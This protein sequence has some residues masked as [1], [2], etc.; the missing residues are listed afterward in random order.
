MGWEDRPYYRDRS[1]S[2]GNI[3][4]SLLTGS[5][6]L[7]TAFG[8]RVRAHASL[9]IL[10]VMVTLF[11]S[12]KGF[13]AIQVR[14]TSMGMLFLIILLHEFGHC[15]AAR[16]VG[17][18]ANEILLWPLGGL[19]LASPPHR[20]W[21]TFVTVAGGPLVNVAICVVAGVVVWAVG[22]G[23][24]SFNPFYIFAPERTG[25][26]LY[27]GHHVAYEVAIYSCWVFRLS[28]W[29]FLFNMIPMFPLDGGQM[30]QSILWPIIGYF[31][32]MHFAC[33]TGM[34]GAVAL[35]IFGLYHQFNTLLVCT[36]IIGF[37][38]CRSRLG[39]LKEM[40]AEEYALENEGIDYSASLRPDVPV[41][42]RR[43]AN[44]WAIRRLR[45]QAQ[46]EAAEQQLIDTILAKVSA[47]GMHSLTW[48]ERRALK[49]ATERQRRRELEPS[50]KNR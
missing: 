42:K 28:Y 11:D 14:A 9:I 12:T 44:R 27:T 46:R 23:V 30:L 7:F 37:L 15:F 26:L 13:D 6:P 40:G 10:I 38:Y 16:S 18:D 5:V 48:S 19:A 4:W 50:H 49:R 3:F 20:P 35:V 24:V 17:G 45:R 2:A 22:G 43:R 8:I 32:S 1:G 47:H 21:P 41:R 29:L 36:G 39:Q 31:K 25:D 33:V 34:V